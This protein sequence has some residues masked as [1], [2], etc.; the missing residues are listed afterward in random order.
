MSQQINLFNPVFLEQKKYFSALAMLQALGLVIGGVLLI[1]MF[2]LH[3]AGQLQA[4]LAG[5][6]RDAEQQREQVVAVGKQ[7]SAL[8]TSKALEEEV[9]RAEEQLRRRRELVSEMTT[10]VGGN[11][12]GFSGY[13]SALARQRIGGVWLTGIEISGK[14]SELVIRGK[15]LNAE[16]VPA[17]V[18]SLSQEEVF[19]GRAVSALQLTARDERAP[20]PAPAVP[21]RYL[22]FNLSIPLGATGSAGGSS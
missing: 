8:G 16:L 21:L 13:L 5:A 2:A 14:A 12:E 7:F 15:A 20:A 18:R 6:T 1:E 19:A 9:P 22:E 17:Y 11:V 3:Q 4:L 10:N